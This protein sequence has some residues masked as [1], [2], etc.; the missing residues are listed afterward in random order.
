MPS[1]IPVSAAVCWRVD[2]GEKEVLC[3][4]CTSCQNVHR[5]PVRLFLLKRLPDK[6]MEAAQKAL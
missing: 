6:R 5:L 2:A 4:Q 1:G 3:V